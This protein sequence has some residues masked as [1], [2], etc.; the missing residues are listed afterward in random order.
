VLQE[1]IIPEVHKMSAVTEDIRQFGAVVVSEAR[2]LLRGLC[3]TQ[4]RGFIRLCRC[5]IVQMAGRSVGGGS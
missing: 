5:C 2:S 3:H 4:G 1:V